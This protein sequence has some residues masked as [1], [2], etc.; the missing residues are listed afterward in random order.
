MARWIWA[1]DLHFDM[2]TPRAFDAFVKSV[3]EKKPSELLIAGDLADSHS[4]APILQKL[5]KQLEIP[6]Y[7]VLGNHDFYGSSIDQVRRDTKLLCQEHPFLYYLTDLEV[8]PLE[9]SIALIGHD[10]WADALSGDFMA[11]SVELRDQYEIHDF[12]RLRKPERFQRL[13]QLGAEAAYD[14]EQKLVKAL[15][16]YTKI[17]LVTHIPPFVEGACYE[18][19]PSNADYAPHFV[20]HQMG[21]MLLRVMKAH[22]DRSLL[23]LSGHSHHQADYHPLPNVH[24]LTGHADYGNPQLQETYGNH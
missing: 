9:D 22:P 12:Q 2:A 11:S 4:L 10:G 17:V 15:K 23:V 20:C 24:C 6:I 14:V 7:F 21:E 3:R 16:D 5:A 1:T 19:K 13:V 8:V 18:N